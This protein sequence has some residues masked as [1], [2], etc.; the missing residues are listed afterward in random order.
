MSGAVN[1]NT[2]HSIARSDYVLDVELLGVL[3]LLNLLAP[4]RQRLHAPLAALNQLESANH[5]PNLAGKV[6]ESLN[7]NM[8]LSESDVA[9]RRGRQ[10]IP[11]HLH[12]PKLR[13]QNDLNWSGTLVT[14]I[15]RDLGN[16]I[17]AAGGSDAFLTRAPSSPH[18]Y[19]DISL[20]GV[21]SFEHVVLRP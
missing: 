19:A 3:I 18:F 17:N 5:P 8:S 21:E 12:H 6:S 16:S 7:Q 2:I 15:R 14:L 20:T 11:K 13:Q 9:E 1:T 4:F 10:G